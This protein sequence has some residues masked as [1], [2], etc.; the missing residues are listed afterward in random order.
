MIWTLEELLKFLKAS[1]LTSLQV[2]RCKCP[3]LAKPEGEEHKTCGKHMVNK[4]CC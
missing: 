1:V 3:L 2:W 4:Y